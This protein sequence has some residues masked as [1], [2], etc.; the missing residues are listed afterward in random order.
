MNLRLAVEGDGV[1]VLDDGDCTITVED[2]PADGVDGVWAVVDEDVPKLGE[3]LGG[4]W[5][6]VV[7]DGA[8]PSGEV[9]E[10]AVLEEEEPGDAVAGDWAAVE[11]A[12]EHGW[13]FACRTC[14]GA[15]EPDGAAV[16]GVLG[17]NGTISD[18]D[19]E[20]DVPDA[21]CA[22]DAPAN[23]AVQAAANSS[24]FITSLRGF[25]RQKFWLQHGKRRA[26]GKT[27]A[28]YE[29]FPIS[30][31]FAKLAGTRAAMGLAGEFPQID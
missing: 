3:V 22:Y 16:D 31:G 4:V 6:V 12:D 5:A 19:D 20:L 26:V 9:D 1:T 7:E 2:E 18:G 23:R 25:G 24:C 29:W 11:P 27:S 14:P 10:L 8:D 30:A 13:P 15:H 21:L 28:I 17:A